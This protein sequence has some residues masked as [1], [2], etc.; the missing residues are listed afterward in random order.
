[1]E[2]MGTCA[3][4]SANIKLKRLVLRSLGTGAVWFRALHGFFYQKNIA[5]NWIPCKIRNC[6]KARGF[7]RNNVESRFNSEM[8]QRICLPVEPWSGKSPYQ[9]A[10][11]ASRPS[12]LASFGNWTF[13][14][15]AWWCCCSHKN[16]AC[17]RVFVWNNSSIYQLYAHISPI[18]V[19]WVNA[20]PE[21][22][23]V[24][25]QLF[26]YMTSSAF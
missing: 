23:I 11:S 8:P 18:S 2:T 22:G 19:R 24:L 12:P 16:L 26:A 1:M 21:D 15:C 9:P 3:P 6:Q 7:I 4:R 10:S 5:S 17:R 20:D 13:T 14:P 25:D